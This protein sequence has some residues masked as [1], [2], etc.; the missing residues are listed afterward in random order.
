MEI[1][2][3]NMICLIDLMNNFHRRVASLYTQSRGKGVHTYFDSE[4]KEI[5]IQEIGCLTFEE[6]NGV[7]SEIYKYRVQKQSDVEYI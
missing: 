5:I 4:G 1:I 7:N 2:K 3:G 6:W